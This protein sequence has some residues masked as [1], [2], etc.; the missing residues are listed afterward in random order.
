MFISSSTFIDFFTI[1][2]ALSMTGSRYGL[3]WLDETWLDLTSRQ[4]M[5]RQADRREGNNPIL[6]NKWKHK[7]LTASTVASTIMIA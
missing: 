4:E 3:I 2:R 6:I 1:A 5:I 7:M